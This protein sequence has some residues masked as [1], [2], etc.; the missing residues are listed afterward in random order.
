MNSRSKALLHALFC[1]GL[2]A[3]PGGLAAQQPAA[4]KRSAFATRVDSVVAMARSQLGRRYLFGGTD[5]DEGFDCSGFTR[6]LARALGVSLP[7]TAAEQAQVGKEVPR[8]VARLRVGDLLT[9]GKDGR[10][11]HVGIYVGNGR[12]IHASSYAGRIIES[13][14]ERRESALIRAWMG[15][16]RLVDPD[17]VTVAAR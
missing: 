8:D 12:F 13:R 6:Y 15:V 3:S 4:P 9:F 10:I 1:A 5:P 14:V 17:S 11:T 7:R 2:L 16:R